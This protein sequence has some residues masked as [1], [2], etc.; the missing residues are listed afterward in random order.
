MLMKQ[1][2][3]EKAKTVLCRIWLWRVLYVNCGIC[4]SAE[5]GMVYFQTSYDRIADCCNRLSN[6]CSCHSG[7]RRS[8]FSD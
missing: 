2:A 5:G 3:A 7:E 8:S 4:R 6:I 1:N